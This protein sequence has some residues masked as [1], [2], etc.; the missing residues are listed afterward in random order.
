MEDLQEEKATLF[1]VSLA[2]IM[3]NII[4]VLDHGQ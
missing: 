3:F 2:N 1:C 4:N